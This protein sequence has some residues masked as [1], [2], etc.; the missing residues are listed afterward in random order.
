LIC[1]CNIHEKYDLKKS[2][3]LEET[4]DSVYEYYKKDFELLHYDKEFKL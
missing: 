4:I 3:P 1:N 2:K